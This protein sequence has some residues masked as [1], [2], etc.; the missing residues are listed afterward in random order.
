M[1]TRQDDGINLLVLPQ[2][3]YEEFG[4]IPRVD[5]LSKRFAGTRYYKLG[6]VLW[7]NIQSTDHHDQRVR[8]HALLERMGRRFTFGEVTLVD[9]TGDDVGVFEVVIVVRS[10]D[11]GGDRRGELASELVVVRANGSNSSYHVSRRF[12][13][14]K[15]RN[16]GRGGG[17]GS[18]GF[19]RRPIS[20]RER[21]QSSTGEVVRGGPSS[22]RWDT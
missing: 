13:T 9:E 15:W 21:I 16:V 6:S 8:N 17:G 5:E 2:H 22:R 19:E 20:S 10:E 14:T 12:E 1:L 3:P 7:E 18:T 4:E 11:V